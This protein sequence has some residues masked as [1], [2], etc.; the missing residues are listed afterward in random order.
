[1]ERKLMEILQRIPQY[2]SA[3]IKG[4]KSF[5]HQMIQ[6]GSFANPYKKN[7][8]EHH[9]T[10]GLNFFLPPKVAVATLKLC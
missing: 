5:P 8:T 9:K 1:M 7:S 10:F 6:A 2:A 4:S 3:G